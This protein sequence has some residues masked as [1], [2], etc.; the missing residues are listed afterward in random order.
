[1]VKGIDISEHNGDINIAGIK[2]AFVIIRAG[3]GTRRDYKVMNNIK[4]CK[5]L[6]IPYGFYWYSYALNATFAK[7]EANLFNDFIIEMKDLGYNPA[8]GVWLDIEDGDRYK[9]KNGFR[10]NYDSIN[11]I[12]Q[13]FVKTIDNIGVYCSESWIQ[14]FE[15]T[16]L[17]LWVA[18]WPAKDDGSVPNWDMSKLADIWQYTTKYLG[19]KL[20]GDIS[21]IDKGEETKPISPIDL[22]YMCIDTMN[23]NYGNGDD[24]IKKLGKYYDKVQ[25][26]INKAY[27]LS[28]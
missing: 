20:D 3:V 2:P 27:E 18:S 23:G 21:Y 8:Y 12:V 6:N 7:Q 1:M 14:F 26:I 17:H 25:T 5:S 10:Y 4:K 16:N 28:E 22:L 19:M 15:H 9:Y 13:V 24:R 11:P